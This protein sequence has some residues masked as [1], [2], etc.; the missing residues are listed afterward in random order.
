ME[1]K[2]H[3]GAKYPERESVGDKMLG[4]ATSQGSHPNNQNET[5]V[6][7]LTK[8]AAQNW[9]HPYRIYTCKK[10]TCMI[11]VLF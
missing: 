3:G 2:S 10:V 4:K 8:M 9:T 7:Q 11:L 5:S 6:H 1:L